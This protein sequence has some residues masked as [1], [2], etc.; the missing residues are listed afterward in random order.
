MTTH[1]VF[2]YGTLMSGEPNHRLLRGSRL[3][4]Q[5]RTPAR[6]HLASL[7]AFPGMVRGGRT[8]VFGEVY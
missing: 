6:Y 1:R 4:R 3:I 2:V 8:S 5:A 7:G